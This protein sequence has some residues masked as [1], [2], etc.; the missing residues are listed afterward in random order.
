M[1]NLTVAYHYQTGIYQ[2][3]HPEWVDTLLDICDPYYNTIKEKTTFS[4]IFPLYQT[5]NM[6]AEKKLEFFQ[7]YVIK[8]SYNILDSQGY[9]LTKHELYFEEIWA[10]EVHTYGHHFPHVHNNCQISGFYFL[11]CPDE[12][13]YPLFYDP[14]PGKTMTDLPEKNRNDITLATQECNYKPKPGQFMF[15]NGWLPHAFQLSSSNATC[16]FIHFNVGAKRI[17]IK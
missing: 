3:F 6:Q 4:K 7:E 11:E 2:S 9:D 10:Q 15:F 17:Y 12:G 1:T 14:R 16:K 5:D 8:E 13:I